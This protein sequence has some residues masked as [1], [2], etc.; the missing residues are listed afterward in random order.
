MDINGVLLLYHLPLE[1]DAA[2][3]LENIQAYQNNS[4]FKVWNV[5]TYLGLPPSLNG[6]RFSAIALHYSIFGNAPFAINEEFVSYLGEST[7]SYKV[8]FFQDE[9]HHCHERFAFINENQI[10]CVYTLIEPEYFDDVYRKYT[11]VPKIIHHL[12]GYVSDGLIELASKLTVPDEQRTID[13]GY[14]ARPLPFY[15]GAGA[16]EKTEIAFE[17]RRRAADTGLRLD[18]ETDEHHRIYGNDWYEFVANCR[19]MIGTEAG[20]S[21][22]DL[23]GHVRQGCE[24]L[25]ALNP[26]M[27]FAEMTAA[28]L[29]KW[30]GRIPQRVISPRHF[31]ASAFRVAQILFEGRYSG[32][33]QAG[34]HYIPLKKDFSNF[35]D[36]IRMFQD[37]ALRHELAEQTYRDIIASGKYTY[38]KFIEGFDEILL[39]AGL[40]PAIADEDAATVSNRLE[41]DRKILEL[42]AR[43]NRLMYHKNFPGRRALSV[44]GGPPLRMLRKLKN[45][46]APPKPPLLKEK[47]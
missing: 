13:V 30:E 28:F 19:A 44:V 16:Q 35:D 38:R 34:K 43:K 32:I 41:R 27:T 6:I 45:A 11:R 22:T 14:R 47:N 7:S 25:L 3:I 42:R 33:L 15:L 40:G 29:H 18:I 31:E 39:E 5:N 10:D 37:K 24:R 2:T 21:I 12:T 17:F 36:C 23:D 26:Q 9:Y 4:R 1:Q 46:I 20:V 8:A